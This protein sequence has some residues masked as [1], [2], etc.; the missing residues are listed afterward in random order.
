MISV[1][2]KDSALALAANFSHLKTRNRGKL[3]YSLNTWGRHI[4]KYFLQMGRHYTLILILDSYQGLR[5][6]RILSISGNKEEVTLFEEQF[7]QFT[8][9]PPVHTSKVKTPSYVF[10][11]LSGFFFF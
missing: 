10:S 7:L 11:L 5:Q 4:N 2:V 8:F 3:L 6:L 1:G 9:S